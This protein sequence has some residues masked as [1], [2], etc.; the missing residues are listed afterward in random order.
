LHA[1][2]TCSTTSLAIVI[3]LPNR[4]FYHSEAKVVALQIIVVLDMV[5]GLMRAYWAGSTRADQTA[6]YTLVLT[7]LV[8]FALY[9]VYTV[10]LLP[11]LWSLVAATVPTRAPEALGS[12]RVP[13]QIDEARS[14]QLPPQDENVGRSISVPRRR[15]GSRLARAEPSPASQMM[16]P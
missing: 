10:Q 4:S 1:G 16:S 8:L 3:L 12:L 14:L 7:L 13:T 11:K 5:V 2:T 6:K 15:G 9:V